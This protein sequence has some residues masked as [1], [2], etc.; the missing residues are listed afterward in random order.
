MDIV[1]LLDENSKMKIKLLELIQTKLG[2]RVEISF[3]AQKTGISK[4]K[5]SKLIHELKM[6]LEQKLCLN[7]FFVVKR[8]VIQVYSFICDEDILKLRQHYLNSSLTYQ[9]LIFL[10]F[11][12]RPINK[13][14]TDH[15]ISNSSLYLYKKRINKLLEKDHLII[16]KNKIVGNEWKIRS[17]GYG[18]LHNLNGIDSPFAEQQKNQSDR[19][20]FWIEQFF[21]I[22]IRNSLRYKLSLFLSISALRIQRKAYLDEAHLTIKVDQT[23]ILVQK[24]AGKLKT[25]YQI[26]DTVAVKEASVLYAYLYVKRI[27]DKKS[28]LDFSELDPT[29]SIFNNNYSSMLKGIADSTFVDQ[30]LFKVLLKN[31]QP[32]HE[33]LLFMPDIH[34]RFGNIHNFQFLREEYPLFDQKVNET[35]METARSILL[36]EEEKADLYMYYMMELIENFPLEAVEE[37]VY[38]TLDFSYG[39]AYEEFIAEHLQYSLAGKI[40]IEKVISSKTD[41]YISDF[42]LGNLQCTHILWQRL[43]NN[44]NWQELIKQIKQCISEKNVVNQKETSNIS[45]TS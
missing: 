35:I 36:N 28:C 12:N 42:H 43:P 5:L 30:R 10:L 26:S 1:Q 13:F 14:T 9:L 11:S 25:E 7:D 29:L 31:V 3:L 17:V 27:I 19:L 32:I 34:H 23:S 18:I 8:G 40:V 4:F 39:K 44:H 21:R 38:I 37:A 33:R 41:I 45:S 24:L 15:Y 6:E 22:R 20:V 2:E 16:K